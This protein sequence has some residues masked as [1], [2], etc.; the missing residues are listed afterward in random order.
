MSEKKQEEDPDIAAIKARKMKALREQAATHQKE[1]MKKQREQQ[2]I[3]SKSDREF[4]LDYLYD[5]GEEVLNLAESQFPTQTKAMVRRIVELL[6]N[7]EIKQ[8]ISGGE[9]LALF[10]FVG[11]NIR[12]NTTI[13]I[14]DH[15][16]LV[17]FSDKLKQENEDMTNT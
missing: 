16:K 6:K 13:K 2:T 15:G 17:S 8:R 5:R 4:I 14:E 11:M 3:K 1:E 7:G 10:R 12:L 9:L